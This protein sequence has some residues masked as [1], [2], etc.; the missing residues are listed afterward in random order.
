MIEIF[1]NLLGNT[2]LKKRMSNITRVCVA[3]VGV[4]AFNASYA[5]AGVFEVI[6]PDVKKGQIEIESLNGVGLSNVEDGEERSV[7]ELAVGYSVTDNWK[8]TV[9]AEVA[10]PEGA[11]LELEAFELESVYILPFSNGKKGSGHNHNHNHAHG[12]HGKDK[13]AEK[14]SG[15]TLGIFTALELPREDTSDNGA[16]E[17]GPVVEAGFGP[18]D[19]V[20]NLFVEVPFSGEDAG[21][22]YASQLIYPVNNNFGIGFESFGEFEG[23][24]GDGDEEELFAGPALYFKSKFADGSL[25]E[26]RLALLFGLN[27]ESADAVLSFNIEYKIGGK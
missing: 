20:G 1:S 3:A 5:G 10:N 9:A 26:P 16:F 19:W 15:W 23:V 14:H 8:V 17:I 6:H 22:V 11:S 18:F 27:D 2:M 13:K 4:A 7:H 12:E 25:F 24:F 21:L